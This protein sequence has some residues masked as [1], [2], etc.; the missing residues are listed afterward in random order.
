MNDETREAILDALD[1]DG[2]VYKFDDGREL[3]LKIEQDV[4]TSPKDYECYGEFSEYSYRY[5][6]R[7]GHTARPDGFDGNAE[8]IE[9][10]YGYWMW[11]Q[12]PR[13]DYAPT[14]ETGKP[15]KRGSQIF[16]DMR[17]NVLDLWHM[18]Y[19]GLIVELWHS[20]PSCGSRHEDNSAALWG[21]EAFVDDGYKREVISDLLDELDL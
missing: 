1:D 11:W 4:D 20:C 13:G 19:V 12:P 17:Q 16:K 15:A 2:D 5:D 3:R 6:Q 14:D 8:K 18:G 21:I 9:V 10:A 7:E